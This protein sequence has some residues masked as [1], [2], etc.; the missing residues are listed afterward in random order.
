MDVFNDEAKK[1]R[2]KRGK[3]TITAALIFSV[4]VPTTCVRKTNL[5]VER[6]TAVEQQ[7]LVDETTDGGHGQA[8]VLDLL[9]LVLLADRGRLGGELQRVESELSGHLS[10]LVHV[11]HRHLPLLSS[12]PRI[13]KGVSG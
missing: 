4:A 9:Q 2:K 13:G 7:R 3:N 10:V 6:D 11:V 5:R 12:M 1:G 8:A